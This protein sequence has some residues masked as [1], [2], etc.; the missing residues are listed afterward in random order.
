MQ[1]LA[2]GKQPTLSPVVLGSVGTRD[3]ISKVT[4]F[5]LIERPLRRDVR[6][7]FL[8]RCPLILSSST[9]SHKVTKE[10]RRH[11]FTSTYCRLRTEY[12][13]GVVNDLEDDVMAYLKAVS[14]NLYGVVKKIH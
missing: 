6:L 11:N 13:E 2:A 12:A 7:V 5:S 10:L 4:T 9:M 14:K 8:S 3:Q 1:K